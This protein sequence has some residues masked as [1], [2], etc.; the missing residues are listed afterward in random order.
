MTTWNAGDSEAPK[1][2]GFWKRKSE[3]KRG[4]QKNG[5]PAELA[6]H[7]GGSIGFGPVPHQPP[8][9]FSSTRGP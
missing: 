6:R 9:G 4:Y 8:K 3:R 2:T 7:W 1:T 5:V